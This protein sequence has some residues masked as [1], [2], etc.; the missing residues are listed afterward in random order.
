M[1]K[2]HYSFFPVQSCHL[3]A[4]MSF[5]FPMRMVSSDDNI[6]YR[7]NYNGTCE[8][9]EHT[10]GPFPKASMSLI[11]EY[12]ETALHFIPDVAR[13]CRIN[14]KDRLQIS[15]D[16]LLDVIIYANIH[17]DY[18]EDWENK[19]VNREKDWVSGVNNKQLLNMAEQLREAIEDS[20]IPQDGYMPS[21]HSEEY[22]DAYER[23]DDELNG[24][25]GDV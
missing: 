20:I 19:I 16:R 6:E 21:A 15:H 24:D 12:C 23:S 9:L 13:K 4:A 17:D 11:E 22:P 3:H 5:Y 18:I 10:I 7:G 14:L 25:F 8:A 1:K 2:P